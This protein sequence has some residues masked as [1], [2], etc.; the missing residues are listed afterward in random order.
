MSLDLYKEYENFLIYGDQWMKYVKNNKIDELNAHHRLIYF[1]EIISNDGA[2]F[3]HFPQNLIDFFTK[4]TKGQYE[5][6]NGQNKSMFSRSYYDIKTGIG[7]NGI[8]INAYVKDDICLLFTNSN[9]SYVLLD[10]TNGK[11]IVNFKQKY[12][13]CF[14]IP[15]KIVNAIRLITKINDGEYSDDNINELDQY[16][17]EHFGKPVDCANNDVDRYIIQ[18]IFKQDYSLFVHRI[19]SMKMMN[20]VDSMNTKINNKYIPLIYLFIDKIRQF[21]EAEATRDIYLNVSNKLVKLMKKIN[22][23]KKFDMDFRLNEIS[24]PIKN[25]LKLEYNVGSVD[26]NNKVIIEKINDIY[27]LLD[28]N[29]EDPTYITKK[30]LCFELCIKLLNENRKVDIN[31]LNIINILI[32]IKYDIL[33]QC[34]TKNSRLEQEQILSLHENFNNWMNL[35]NSN[36]LYNLYKYAYFSILVNYSPNSEKLKIREFD[37]I[38]SKSEK[39]DDSLIKE[40]MI[41]THNL[42]ILN[43]DVCDHYNTIMNSL[44]NVSFWF[45]SNGE[46][47]NILKKLKSI[48][49]ENKIYLTSELLDISFINNY[50]V[51]IDMHCLSQYKPKYHT[52][53]EYDE[54]SSLLQIVSNCKYMSDTPI[55]N[56]HM[57]LVESPNKKINDLCYVMQINIQPKNI[58][59]K[60]EI[61][62][63]Y[64]I[65]GNDVKFHN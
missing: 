8:S 53:K 21:N 32:K 64:N 15:E 52:F 48:F 19:R 55:T 18:E 31:Y 54:I 43:L 51:K 7:L 45:N 36:Q 16:Y 10:K 24:Q 40:F 33:Y 61:S 49:E 65:Y 39:M 13:K 41:D 26:I 14:N 60:E 57:Y 56:T 28:V 6:I 9:D 35:V 23:N 58:I 38:E 37:E 3:N 5:Y 47:I 25:N 42:L 34:I 27:K 44:K 63:S 17:S 4:I 46:F 11:F 62:T 59:L 50:V 30:I 2:L 1:S 22:Q 29:L 20:I 12:V